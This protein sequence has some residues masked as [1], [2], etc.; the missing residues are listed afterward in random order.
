METAD[1]GLGRPDTS[2]GVLDA[3][4]ESSR[5]HLSGSRSTTRR[6]ESAARRDDFAA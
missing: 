3:A 2:V 6:R 5:T 1:M 4:R